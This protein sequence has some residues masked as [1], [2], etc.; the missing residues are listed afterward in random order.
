MRRRFSADC[1]AMIASSAAS[2]LSIARVPAWVCTAAIAASRWSASTSC[3]VTAISASLAWTAASS[4]ATSAARCGGAIV[5]SAS[6]D[7]CTLVR[8]V[9]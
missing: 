9:S 2:A 5:R 4:W 8:I 7:A 3:T 6:S 1:V